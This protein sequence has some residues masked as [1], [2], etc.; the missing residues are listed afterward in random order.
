MPGRPKPKARAQNAGRASSA[1]NVAK[2]TVKQPAKQSSAVATKPAHR[3]FDEGVPAYLE[4]ADLLLQRAVVRIQATPRA[5]ASPL[6]GLKV[7]DAD[8][9]RLVSELV[10]STAVP[11]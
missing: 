1:R 9:T 2:K 8:V 3:S 4:F 7:D 5:V 6:A 10:G 11:V